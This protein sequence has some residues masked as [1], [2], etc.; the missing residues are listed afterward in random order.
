[1]VVCLFNWQID[2]CVLY[3]CTRLL[4]HARRGAVAPFTAEAVAAS[5]HYQHAAVPRTRPSENLRDARQELWPRCLCQAASAA[6]TEATQHTAVANACAPPSHRRPLPSPHQRQVPH[7][8]ACTVHAPR[9]CACL[10]AFLCVGASA[11]ACVQT[12]CWR[13]PLMRIS[14]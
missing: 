14:V 9:L 6:H 12:L 1:M 7:T 3:P 2:A 5:A 8:R 11:G 10:C 13:V 4:I